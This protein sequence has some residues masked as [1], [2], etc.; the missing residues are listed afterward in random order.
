MAARIRI[1][2]T[3]ALSTCQRKCVPTPH[4]EQTALSMERKNKDR[5]NKLAAHR[6]ALPAF[7]RFVM[8]HA[9][10]TASMA[11]GAGR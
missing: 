6:S 2:R 3:T 9:R 8:R 7:G 4:V 5:V 1:P 10:P 11:R